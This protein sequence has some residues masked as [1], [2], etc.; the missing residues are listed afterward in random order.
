VFEG[1]IGKLPELQTIEKTIDDLE[2]KHA[3]SQGRVQALA[4][5]VQQ[6]R[7]DDLN[8][9]ALALN[10]GRKVPNP[11]EGH[12][13]SQLEGAQRDLQV[14]ERRLAL[15][16]ADRARYISEH[17]AEILSHLGEAHAAEGARVAAAASEALEALLAYH[18]AEDDARNLQRLHPAPAPENVGSPQN[19]VTVWGAL[20]TRN[21]AGGPQRGDLEGTLQYLV[22]L[23]EATIVEAVE[24]DENAA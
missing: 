22:S 20:T 4:L 16:V 2:R 18:R 5:K 12:L 10:R 6:A 13:A 3:E 23:G 9:E 11:T 24:D 21:Y 17:H 14:L 19:S 1:I 8:R 7:E 15:A